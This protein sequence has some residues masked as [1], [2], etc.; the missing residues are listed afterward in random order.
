[1]TTEK[2][3]GNLLTG[4]VRRADAELLALAEAELPSRW[5]FTYDPG[6]SIAWNLYQFSGALESYKRSC[7]RWEEHHNG[8]MCVVERVRDKYLMPKIR[9]F[10]QELRT[11]MSASHD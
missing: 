5:Y 2:E 6:L 9:E 10:E 1:M 4:I 8:S 3:I 11:A 7:R